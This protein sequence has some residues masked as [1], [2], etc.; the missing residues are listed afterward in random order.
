MQSIAIATA[1]SAGLFLA[2]PLVLFW[3]FQ[4]VPSPFPPPTQVSRDRGSL[5]VPDDLPEPIRRYLAS[6]TSADLPQVESA[7]IWGRA[8]F[9]LGF[10]YS[11]LRFKSFYRQGEFCREM[12]LTWFGLPLM[13]AVDSYIGGEGK[14]QVRGLMNLFQTG[15]EIAEGQVLALWAEEVAML[16]PMA[17]A[18]PG[19]RWEAIDETHCSAYLPF[20]DR[21]VRLQ[22]A[23]DPKTAAIARIEALR[24]RQPGEDRIPWEITLSELRSFG[25][26]RV[27]ARAIVRWQDDDRPY[28]IGTLEG[29]AYNI[30]V[31]PQI[32]PGDRRVDLPS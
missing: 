15:E 18:H 26:L 12:E 17:I 5:G 11:M 4:I 14:L 19:V 1:I 21:E 8:K 24:Y 25:P 13:R 7:M 16:P 2:L 23:F 10:A 32:P 28:W 27:P 30:D 20:G 22:L 9:K 29:I 31:S 3:G 6:C